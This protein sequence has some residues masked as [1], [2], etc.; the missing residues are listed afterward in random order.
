[1]LVLREQ[2]IDILTT[3][4]EYV[5]KFATS[6]CY[7]GQLGTQSLRVVKGR[8]CIH[9]SKGFSSL[10]ATVDFQAIRSV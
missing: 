3:G 9:D 7:R 10:Q 4:G 5:E 6:L 1:M 8:S 2:D